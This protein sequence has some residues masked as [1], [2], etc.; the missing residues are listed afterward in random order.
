MNEGGSYKVSKPGDKPKLVERTKDHPEG[1]RP[2]D[3]KGKPLPS[4]R[5]QAAPPEAAKPAS[6]PKSDTGTKE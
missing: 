6:A 5:D 3:A 4:A 1:N 2:R